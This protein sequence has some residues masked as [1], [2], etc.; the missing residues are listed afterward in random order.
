MDG[1]IDSMSRRIAFS[2]APERR[3]REEKINLG[4]H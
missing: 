1:S 4:R 2:G 3:E